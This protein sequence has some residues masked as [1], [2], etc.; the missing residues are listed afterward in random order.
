[1]LGA[2]VDVQWDKQSIEFNSESAHA[3]VKWSD[4]S[5]YRENEKLFLLYF[6]DVMFN[7]I[8]KTAFN[9]KEQ[10]ED[11]KSNLSSIG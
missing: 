5:K 8:P 11:F 2:A 9:S 10:L 6:S 1:M 7:I 4:F 3:K